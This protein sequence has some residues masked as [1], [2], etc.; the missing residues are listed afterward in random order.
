MLCDVSNEPVG[1]VG[2][3]NHINMN[4]SH[5]LRKIPCPKEVFGILIRYLKRTYD[6][7]VLAFYDLLVHDFSWNFTSAINNYLILNQTG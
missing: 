7:V 3:G 5:T 1:T 2:L 4:C 6:D